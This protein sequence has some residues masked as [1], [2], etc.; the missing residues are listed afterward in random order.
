VYWNI[1]ILRS[2]FRL[3]TVAA[4]EFMI[5]DFYRKVKL[6]STRTLRDLLAMS[7]M[8]RIYIT[9]QPISRVLLKDLL[10]TEIV[11]SNVFTS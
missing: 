10:I 5:L 9:E 4:M 3:G 1:S 6:D 2:D 7:T 8:V 11:N